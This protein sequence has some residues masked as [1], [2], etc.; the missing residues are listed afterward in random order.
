VAQEGAFA[1][2]ALHEVDAHAGLL[3]CGD[4]EHQ[5]GK[6][7]SGADVEPGPGARGMLEELKRI[8]DV[9]GPDTL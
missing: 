2:V 3:H 5:A 4:A 9:P 7:G 1:P 6:A 8:G